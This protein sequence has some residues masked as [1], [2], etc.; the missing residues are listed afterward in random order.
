[1]KSPIYSVYSLVVS[2]VRAII[3]SSTNG[4]LALLGELWAR[5]EKE[6]LNNTFSFF[7]WATNYIASIAWGT[8]IVLIVPFVKVYIGNIPEAKMYYQPLFGILISLAYAFHTL[9]LP[10]NVLILA[11]NQYKKTQNIYIIAVAINIIVSVLTV[12]TFGLEGVAIGTLASMVYQSISM[13]NYAYENMLNKNFNF[14]VKQ[15]AISSLSI[16]VMVIIAITVKVSAN[17]YLQWI[18][19]AIQFF[20]ISVGVTTL[21]NLIFYRNNI[22]RATKILFKKVRL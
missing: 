4:I 22:T 10:Y 21:L 20:S 8:T 18:A 11:G 3:T 12:S 7:E 1:M 6:S 13:A 19:I 16:I 17:S 14:F 5:N 15:F 2:G 9:R